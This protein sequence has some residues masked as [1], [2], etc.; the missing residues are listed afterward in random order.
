V[1]FLE[2]EDDD[3]ERRKRP[4][5]QAAEERKIKTDP[6]ALDAST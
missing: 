3:P 1:S 5:P 6:R 2:D 4:V